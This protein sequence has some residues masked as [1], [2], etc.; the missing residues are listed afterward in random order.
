MVP[1]LEFHHIKERAAA[2][3][4][5]VQAKPRRGLGVG[6]RSHRRHLCPSSRPEQAPAKDYPAPRAPDGTSPRRTI[7]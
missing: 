4:T 2:A 5:A 7:S 3:Q 6:F 1:G